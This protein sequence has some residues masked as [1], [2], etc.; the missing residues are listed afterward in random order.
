MK[1]AGVA[2]ILAA[3]LAG[4]GGVRAEDD[5]LAVVKKAVAGSDAAKTG[6]AKPQWLKIRVHERDGGKV[7]VNMPLSLVRAFGDDWPIHYKCGSDKERP[8]RCGLKFSEILARLDAGQS[9]VEIDE[10][11]GDTVR[12]WV[13]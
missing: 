10:E 7:T 5:D 13:E 6:G 2:V 11:G 9:L 4:G 3:F 1:L 8:A 12:I